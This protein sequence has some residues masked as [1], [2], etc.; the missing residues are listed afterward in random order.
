MLSRSLF[1]VPVALLS[2]LSACGGEDA[3]SI[4]TWQEMLTTPAT[5][6]VAKPAGLTIVPPWG[7][8]VQHTI[9][10]GYGTALHDN[11]NDTLHTNDYYAL[12]FDLS[13]N[14][15][16]Y[17]VADGQVVF[18]GETKGGFD[19]YGN[20]V[21]IRHT[22]GGEQFYSFYAHLA[23][24]AVATGTTVTTST[25]IG[26]A[27]NS[28]SLPIGVHLHFALSRNALFINTTDS[29]GPYGGQAV[30]PEAFAS[31]TKNGSS[32]CE[33]LAAGDRLTRGGTTSTTS[34][35]GS[36]GSGG[37]GGAGGSGGSGG[38]GG[39]GG[40]SCGS[41]CTQC[42]LTQRTDVLPFYASNGWDTTCGNRDS[43]VNNWCSI[44][45]ASCGA[46]RSG[47][48]AAACG[49]STCGSPCTQCVLTQRTDILPF[50]ASS[51]WDTSCGNRDS[52]VSN[53]CGIDPAGCNTVRSGSCSA[54]CG[55]PPPPLTITNAQIEA[56]TTPQF[57]RIDG[58]GPYGGW[59]LHSSYPRSGNSGLGQRFGFYSAGASET[60]GQVLSA[61]FAANRVYTFRSFAQ[62]GGDNTGTVPYE[63]GYAS[64][65]GVLSSFRLLARQ[66]R[67]TG[68]AWVK[69]SGV[70]YITGS[71]GAELGKQI[72]VRLG[73]GA[74][75]GSSDIWFDNLELVPTVP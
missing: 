49:T 17:P 3:E 59:A 68:A 57:G 41:T 35:T 63:I 65:D 25:R 15:S 26:A 14:E 10:R 74:A 46:V 47:S 38:A 20:I 9:T 31:C 6:A 72:I 13:L 4:A 24:T 45:P 50:Y 66:V 2:M 42:V 22:V 37:S 34:T 19:P 7:T 69:T 55:A 28:G 67:S 43:I 5:G 51:G 29:K 11:T 70:T 16:V 75:G 56:V 54:T 61:R 71:T 58:F 64:T 48:C 1:I 30:V 53:W 32:S 8:G 12:D 73:D 36:G 44:D 21:F 62:G 33:N 60:V 40:G 27:G 39:G 52:I 23:S 18:A